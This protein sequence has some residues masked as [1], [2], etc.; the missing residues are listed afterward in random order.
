ML[1]PYLIMGCLHLGSKDTDWTLAYEYRNWAKRVGAKVILAGDN[2][3]CCIPCHKPETMWAQNLTPQ[4][5][6]EKGLEFYGPI[7]KQII[8]GCTSNHSARIW[9]ATSIDLD[10]NLARELGYEYVGPLGQRNIKVGRI[11]YKITLSHGQAG[12]I[13]N[14]WGDAFKI[15]AVYPD[16]DIVLLS[17]RHKMDQTLEMQVVRGRYRRVQFVRTGS[18][19]NYARYA[20]NALYPPS[21]KGFA[22]VY[23]DAHKKDFRVD[24]SGCVPK[25]RRLFS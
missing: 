24:T 6:Y 14:P 15:M 7:K 4:E 25:G 5:Q 18:L 12:G 1:K 23:L 8:L 22:I 17:H 16:T 13:R 9:K 21:A 2:F 3:D 11:T 10:K 19:M 20:K